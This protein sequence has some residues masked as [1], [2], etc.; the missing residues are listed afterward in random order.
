MEQASS[1]TATQSDVLKET[2]DFWESSTGFKGLGR[3]PRQSQRYFHAF[4]LASYAHPCIFWPSLRSW[5]LAWANWM[6]L[7]EV[8]S[9]NLPNISLY[10]G[11]GE[12][13]QLILPS[14]SPARQP[15]K[16]ITLLPF[17]ILQKRNQ[18]SER[19]RAKPRF[20]T[21]S[22]DVKPELLPGGY[23][24]CQHSENFWASCPG[25]SALGCPP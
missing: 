1:A 7:V 24:Q 17:F 14:P 19:S 16:E 23:H 3:E 9:L 11:A 13:F 12:V 18:S 20:E 10:Q 2:L 15:V 21:P 4:G 8:S 22:F 25:E 6:Q 5:L